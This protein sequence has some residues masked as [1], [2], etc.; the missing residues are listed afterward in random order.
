MKL[1]QKVSVAV[2]KPYDSSSPSQTCHSPFREATAGCLVCSDMGV[3]HADLEA[4][5]DGGFLVL[6]GGQKV[7]L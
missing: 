3:S 7:L 1:S 2:Q 5:I 4:S 6:S